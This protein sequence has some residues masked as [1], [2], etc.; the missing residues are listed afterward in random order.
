MNTILVTGAT[1]G[2]GLATVT[3][4]A[5]LG[6][7]VVVHG[8]N[9]DKALHACDAIRAV[10]PGAKLQTAYA[11]LSDLS[12]VARMAHELCARLPQLDVLINNAG[13]YK[14]EW[15]IS[16]DGFEMTL[17]VNHLAHF[18]LTHLLLPLLKKSA[19]P[20]VVTVS[21]MVHASGRIV[22]DDMNGD[23]GYNA[24]HAYANSKLA[25][26]LFANELARRE[27]WLT[28]NSLHPGVIGTKLLHAAFSMP[29]EAAASGAR[30]SV[31]LATSDEVAGVTGKYFDNCTEVA[32]AAQALDRQL[33]RRLWVW[34]EEALRDYLEANRSGSAGL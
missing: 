12:A 18:L 23:R 8:R 25:N 30:T 31:Y 24:Y 28:S 5:R 15:E 13:V 3:E 9:E 34:S 32:A 16:P 26:A 27:P 7:E 21:S 4:L 17:A 10:V 20:R 22:F 29:G 11:D 33:V 1:D 14:T 6:H 2:I 19:A